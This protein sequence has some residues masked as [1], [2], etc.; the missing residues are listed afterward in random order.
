MVLVVVLV[1]VVFAAYAVFPYAVSANV[2]S[3]RAGSA[4][5]VYGKVTS[6][7]LALGN[8]SVFQLSS[9]SS[10]IY[11]E[12]EGG[13]PGAGSMVLVHGEVEEIL[14]VTYIRAD[15]VYYWPL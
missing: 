15:A 2:A 14:G 11:V 9:G 6:Q 7:R 3:L 1:A 13:L 4:V 12:W 10:S 8:I 5:Y